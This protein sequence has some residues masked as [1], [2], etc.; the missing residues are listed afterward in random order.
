MGLAQAFRP[1]GMGCIEE[2]SIIGTGP[3]FHERLPH[4]LNVSK[5][6]VGCFHQTDNFLCVANSQ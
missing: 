4:Q 2:Q 1:D 6:V 3:P 5:P